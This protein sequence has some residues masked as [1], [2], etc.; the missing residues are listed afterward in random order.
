M[1]ENERIKQV[2]KKLNLTLSV[3]GQRIGI[4]SAALSKVENGKRNIT[5]QVRRAVCREFG[6]DENWLLTGEGDMF[7]N[8]SASIVDE[9]AR[10][11]HLTPESKVLIER[12]LVLSPEVQKGILDYILDVAAVL[13]G[14]SDAG[15]RELTK[16]EKVAGYRRELDEAEEAAERSSALQTQ[17][18]DTGKMA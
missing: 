8:A 10:Q 12:F 6:V 3:F 14:T 9:I 18:D 5:E 4:T 2:R 15:T 11:Y 17:S 1:T 13:N 7:T 16:E